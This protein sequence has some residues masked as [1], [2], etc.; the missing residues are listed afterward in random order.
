MIVEVKRDDLRPVIEQDL[1]AHAAGEK[2]VSIEGRKAVA[3]KRWEEINPEHLSYT[4]VFADTH[5]SEEAL[6]ETRHF[7]SGK[8]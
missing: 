8:A 3:L 1:K 2:L 5:V 6:Q 7:I 4:L